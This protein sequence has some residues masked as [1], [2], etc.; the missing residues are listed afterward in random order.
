[1]QIHKIN[2]TEKLRTEIIQSI[3][4]LKKNLNIYI[5]K[6]LVT[7]HDMHKKKNQSKTYREN[8]LSQEEI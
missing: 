2:L 8:I 6:I 5:Y 3:Y 1:M 4:V 7:A